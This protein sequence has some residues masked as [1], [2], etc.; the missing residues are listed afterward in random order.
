MTN[1]KNKALA[2]A[3]RLEKDYG[4]RTGSIGSAQY[5][6]NVIPT[7]TLA[8]DYALGTGGWPRGHPVE[9][10]GPPDIGKSSTL[11]L[12]AI[13]NSQALGL[14][15]GVIAMEPGFDPAWAVKN[16][17]DPDGLVVARPDHGEAAFDILY[18]WMTGDV[19][20]FVLFD[21]IGAV[22]SKS[23]LSQDEINPKMGG[24]SR[25]ITEGLKRILIPCWKNNKGL[26]LLN[27]VRDVMGSPVSGAVESPGG[28]ALKHYAAIRVQL[29]QSGRPLTT[30]IEGEDVVVART[31]VAQLKRNKLDEGTNKRAEFDYWQKAI[32]G[33]SIGIDAGKDIVSTAIRMRVI[34]KAGA[35][36]SSPIFPKDAPKLQGRPAVEEYVLTQPGLI[37][38]IR[39]EVLAKMPSIKNVE[40]VIEEDG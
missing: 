32:E 38:K 24:E 16:G 14:L 21:S 13:R 34:D 37:D 3:A 28:R 9:V 8:L 7:G 35:W 23:S 6:L 33:H 29:K 25:L 27:Q 18:E 15:C 40:P 10:F 5:Q 1:L 20:D 39:A 2:E 17:V 19:V 11:G 4:Q 30:K 26:V 31:L 12:S 36:F 22:T